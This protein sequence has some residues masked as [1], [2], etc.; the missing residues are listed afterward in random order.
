MTGARPPQAALTRDNDP[1]KREETRR[2]IEAMV[3]GLNDHQIN[4]MAAF[5][6]P[7]FRWMGNCGCGVK[8]GLR[9]FQENWQRPFQAAFSDKVAIDEARIFD[10]EWGACF[11]AQHAVHSGEFMG[12]PA[13]GKRVTIRYMD[14]WKVEDGKIVDNWVMVDFPDVLRQLGVDVFAGKG[15]EIYD[16]GEAVPPRPDHDK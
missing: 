13:T 2:V 16:R 4:G 10:G 6:H 7:A 8:N 11:G 9:E 12:V 14:F 3:D 5:F 1:T 15:W